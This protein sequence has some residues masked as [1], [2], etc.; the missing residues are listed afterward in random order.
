[1]KLRNRTGAATAFLGS[2]GLLAFALP[3]VFSAIAPAALVAQTGA[4]IHGFAKDPAGQ[5]YTSGEIRFSTD[6][7]D[8]AAKR[9]FQ[10]TVPVGS[11]G[12]YKATNVAPGAYIIALF[13]DGISVYFHEVDIN[14]G[15][16]KT[17]NFDLSS[18]EY[19][20]GLSPEDRAKLEEAKKRNAAALA[21]NSKI[22]DINKTLNQ[23]V[24]D[25]N[26]GK[27]DA[28]V[29]ELTPL[30]VQLP[31]EPIVWA[32]L[33]RAQLAAAEAARAA[34]RAAKT[35]TGDPAILQ[36][37]SDAAASYQ[38]SLD[39]NAATKK[40]DNSFA[41]SGYLNL[42]QALSRFGKTD[43]AAAAYENAAK[44]DPTKAG[45]AYYDEAAIYEN[46]DKLKEANEAAD[47]A[48]AADPKTA[49]AYYI[50]AQALVPNATLDPATKKFVLPPGCLEAY[51]KYLEL[52]PTGAHAKDVKELLASFGQAQ[53][54]SF[55]AKK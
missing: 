17:V 43:E 28:A 34:A 7:E 41:F 19:L 13:R 46:A 14:K 44:A 18:A 23:A 45:I 55:K 2:F 16:D 53:K 49:E 15:D 20:K 36:K 11:D 35:P 50:K 48:I 47:K 4:T 51:Q 40:P 24:A 9:T 42:G 10:Y 5:P 21:E 31:N 3:A 25:E 29:A 22:A 30:S 8:P 39:L 6:K 52:A 32:Q 26:G 1:M 27:P 38:K 54:D 33:G 37:Y 12:T